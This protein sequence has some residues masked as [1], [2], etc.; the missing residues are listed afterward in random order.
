MSNNRN[1]YQR[2][3]ADVDGR[4]EAERADRVRVVVGHIVRWLR[5]EEAN[6]SVARPPPC[7]A[8]RV[9]ERAE[10]CGHEESL[11]GV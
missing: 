11:K 8:T 9:P 10:N 6:G 3:S 4:R 5:D 2:M 1:R 7:R